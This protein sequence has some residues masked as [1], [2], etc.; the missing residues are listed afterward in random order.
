MNARVE[1]ARL[2]IEE[3]FAEVVTI[4]DLGVQSELSPFH[5]IRA[6]QKEYGVSPHEYLVQVRVEEA[7]KLLQTG[8]PIVQVAHNTGFSDQS[9]LTRWFKT[10]LGITPGRYR[11][12]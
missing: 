6:F 2:Y 10:R 4:H 3:H 9:H 5:L 12:L 11:K 7:R 8:L 1:K